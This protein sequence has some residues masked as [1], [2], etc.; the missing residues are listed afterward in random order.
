MVRQ[1]KVKDGMPTAKDWDNISALYLRG[2]TLD[3]I[4]KAY[5]SLKLNKSTIMSKMSKL[6]YTAKKRAIDKKVLDITASNVEEQKIAVSNECIGMFNTG[7]EVIKML[8]DNYLEELK[9][10]ETSASKARATAYNT[11]L[12]MDGITKIQKGLRVA[13]DMD[14]KDDKLREKAP[15][16][17]VIEGV[18]SGKI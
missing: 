9:D 15:E 12:L 10:G 17:L 18:D 11:N 13:Y 14:N 4:I 6:G 7:A 2:E 5:P 3:Y 1:V 16:V 8:L